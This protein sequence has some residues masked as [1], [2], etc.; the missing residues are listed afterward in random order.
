MSH[1]NLAVD[2]TLGA[3]AS[4]GTNLLHRGRER[5][6]EMSTGLHNCAHADLLAAPD[7]VARGS[8]ACARTAS[9]FAGSE[10]E[11][12]TG[13]GPSISSLG[14]HRRGGRNGP[15]EFSAQ[16]LEA[17]GEIPVIHEQ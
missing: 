3:L 12:A 14:R 17:G 7:A 13:L 11:Q 15:F 6:A 9:F 8:A 10:R 2:A 1:P 4:A 16:R 5:M